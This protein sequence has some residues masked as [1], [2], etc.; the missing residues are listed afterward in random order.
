M[1][2]RARTV[3]VVVTAVAGLALVIA[4][5]QELSRTSA[6]L[7]ERRAALATE[8]AR[9]DEAET[10]AVRRRTVDAVLSPRLDAVRSH[11]RRL[12][13]ALRRRTAER[14]R[15]QRSVDGVRGEVEI[16]QASLVTTVEQL[17]SQG[18]RIGELQRCLAGVTRALNR[19]SLDDA[20]GALRSLER[21]S[22]HCRAAQADLADPGSGR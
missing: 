2:A 1:L 12:Q 15:L 22:G 9:L 17:S 10:Q 13:E 6:D 20:D 3:A 18:T 11:L 14:D 4:A 8:R 5:R 16:L 21:T 7:D 19:A